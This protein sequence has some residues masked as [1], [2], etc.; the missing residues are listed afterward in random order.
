[1]QGLFFVK[2]QFCH[3]N[4]NTTLG[5]FLLF[6]FFISLFAT[7]IDAQ[8]MTV[9]EPSPKEQRAAFFKQLEAMCGSEAEGRMVFPESGEIDL[10]LPS[11][12]DFTDKDLKMIFTAC[13]ETTIEVDFVV[14][15]DWS[16]RWVF[17]NTEEELVLKIYEVSGKE[18]EI[19][20][21]V[22]EGTCDL[23]KQRERKAYFEMADLEGVAAGQVWKISLGRVGKIF[24]V[25]QKEQVG[26]RLRKTFHA[27]FQ[28]PEEEK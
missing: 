4:I 5:F 17:E 9:R 6:A 20:T 15:D 13:T 18:R 14:G 11:K 3:M 28:L 16:R 1:M 7:S 25:S 12:E 2:S 26:E 23:N 22:Q 27:N 21:L 10:E 8:D 24:S 19:V